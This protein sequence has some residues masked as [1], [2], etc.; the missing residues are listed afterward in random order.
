MTLTNFE[1]KVRELIGD[2]GDLLA[3]LEP[4]LAARWKVHEQFRFLENMLK[5]LVNNDSVCRRLMT[6]P[7]VGPL[8]AITFKTCIDDPRR[9][10]K[11]RQV[12][13]HLGLTPRK[14]ASGD[15]DFNGH[16]T[17]SGDS[18]ARDHLFEAAPQPH[19]P[20]WESGV[21]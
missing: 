20:Q 18:L 6:V 13:V 7:G 5:R 10:G 3:C 12:G 21:P 1:P 11:S 4:M 14:Y 2:D 8:T 15:V 16:I 17:R 9:F 19:G